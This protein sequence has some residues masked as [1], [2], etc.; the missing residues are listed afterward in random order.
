MKQFDLHRFGWTLKN[1]FFVIG[2]TWLRI[3]GIYTLVLFLIDLFL[4]RVLGINYNAVLE[5]EGIEFLRRIYANTVCQTAQFGLFFL[6]FA[7]LFCASYLF[8]FLKTKPQRSTYLML[9][10]SNMEKYL[11]SFLYAVVLMFIGTFVAYCVADTLRML[12]DLITGRVV[13]WGVPY[14]FEPF[15]FYDAPWLLIVW[16]IGIMLYFHSVYILGG[17]LFRK[18]AP[19]LTSILVVIGFF[20]VM[21][22]IRASSGWI[23]WHAFPKSYNFEGEPVFHWLFY[24]LIVLAYLLTAI[25]YWLSYRIFCRMQVINHKW[26]NV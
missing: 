7:M 14:F 25:H 4:T 13:I 11:V 15:N 23:D 3:I 1:Y 8:S 17:T 22:G 16:A 26:L 21:W 2:P 10:A 24:V 6:A 5:N 18:L 12:L 9:P 19:L 20:L